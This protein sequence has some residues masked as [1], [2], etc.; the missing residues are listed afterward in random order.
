MKIRKHFNQQNEITSNLMLFSA[1]YMYNEYL[2]TQ[3]QQSRCG[4]N[5]CDKGI[6][7]VSENANWPGTKK[8]NNFVTRITYSL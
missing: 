6:I 1:S 8:L 7:I 2:R 4:M 5:Q 3:Q